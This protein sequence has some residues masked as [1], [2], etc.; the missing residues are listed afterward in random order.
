MLNELKGRDFCKYTL[1]FPPAWSRFALTWKPWRGRRF[2]QMNTSHFSANWHWNFFPLSRFAKF[3]TGLLAFVACKNPILH[4]KNETQ[5]FGEWVYGEVKRGTTF[6]RKSSV[7]KVQIML[8]RLGWNFYTD[9][10]CH[11]TSLFLGRHSA[12]DLNS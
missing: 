3:I 2:F 7:E 1:R 8:F 5:L 4:N 12:R 10:E 9:R 6:H 11:K